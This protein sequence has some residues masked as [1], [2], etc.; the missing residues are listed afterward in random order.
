MKHLLAE[1]K[2]LGDGKIE[3][4]GL[5]WVTR[6]PSEAGSVLD[7]AGLQYTIM[8]VC[9]KANSDVDPNKAAMCVHVYGV[10]LSNT[11]LKDTHFYWVPSPAASAQ[12]ER[13]ICAA[14]QV[15]CCP[16]AGV[17]DVHQE[18]RS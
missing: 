12:T 11:Q 5:D 17:P 1:K 15:E 7:K 13:G 9:T 4:L 2:K 18:V 3:E 8:Q 14:I 16:N 6:K 10:M